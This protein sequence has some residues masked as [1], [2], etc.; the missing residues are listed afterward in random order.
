M[1]ELLQLPTPGAGLLCKKQNI[2]TENFK[3]VPKF[4]A[5]ESESWASGVVFCRIDDRSLSL[6]PNVSKLTYGTS[7]MGPFVVSTP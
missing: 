4:L 1:A 2:L 3:S 7:L 5:S 6:Q